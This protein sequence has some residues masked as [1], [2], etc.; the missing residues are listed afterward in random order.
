MD[1]IDLETITEDSPSSPLPENYFPKFSLPNT[2]GSG[3]SITM[4]NLSFGWDPEK[5]ILRDITLS[6]PLSKS[7]LVVGPVGSGKSTLCKALLGEI[8]SANGTVRFPQIMQTIA[9]C[10]QAA[11]LPNGTIRACILGASDADEEW[12]SIV[13]KA[14]ELR[15]DL[16][17][18]VDGDS[19]SIGSSGIVLSGGQKLRLALA[20]ALYARAKTIILDDVFSGLDNT[21][22]TKICENLFGRNGL[23]L[24]YG[25][26]VILVSHNAR[27]LHFA[28]HI[29]AL[30]S[31]GTVVEAGS[32]S[33]LQKDP[34]YVALL[35]IGDREEVQSSSLEFKDTKTEKRIPGIAKPEAEDWSRQT[36]D[37]AI[38]RYYFSLFGSAYIL[39]FLLTCSAV[40]FLFNFNN[41]WLKFWSDHI[42]ARPKEGRKGY[43]L[44]IYATIQ[45]C[46]L[47]ALGVFVHHNMVTMAVRTGVLL[48]RKALSTVM[49]ARLGFFTRTDVGT[50][51]N[52][53]SQDMTIVDGQL[54]MGLS[55]TAVTSAVVLG[56]AIVIALASP[57]LVICYPFLL[58]FL[59]VIQKVY[60]RTSR[61]LRFLDLEAKAPL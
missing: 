4:Q 56:Q 49:A 15:H 5:P 28:D 41:V 23:L 12:Y 33:E 32:L 25:T 37:L 10:D 60:L 7:T 6:I 58:A 42:V 53:F 35:A 19:T 59:Y 52:R 47:T 24:S 16:E 1:T 14:T 61:Q 45:I 3:N 55:N 39:Y 13:L 48:H 57:Y 34:K 20:R 51:I 21:T 40:G 36:G 17:Q 31:T 38:Y 11:W 18:L 29:I 9:F 30:S 43:Y 26:T 44:G 22:E 54:A 50:T 2:D 8:S 27:H 46:A